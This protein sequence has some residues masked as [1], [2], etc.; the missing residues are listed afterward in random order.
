[1]V[2]EK[3]CEEKCLDSYQNKIEVWKPKMFYSRNFRQLVFFV[4]QLVAAA[5]SGLSVL[6]QARSNEVASMVLL[7]RVVPI[8]ASHWWNGPVCAVQS[9]N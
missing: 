4:E 7:A 2:V 5:V 1:M 6:S 8:Q 9:L 3:I